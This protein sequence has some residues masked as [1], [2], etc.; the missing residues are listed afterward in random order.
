MKRLTYSPRVAVVCVL[1]TAPF[2]AASAAV[3]ASAEEAQRE[4]FPDASAFEAVA[5]NLSDA[6]L[7]E[8]A[9]PQVRRPVTVS[10]GSGRRGRVRP[11]SVMSSSTK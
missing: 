9:R 7:Q 3:Y 8:I 2:Q 11:C 4:L 6:Q 10:C 1:A 5:L